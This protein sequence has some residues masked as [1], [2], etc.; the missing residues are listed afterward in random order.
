MELRRYGR[1]LWK[2]LWLIVL[3]GVIAGGVTFFVSSRLTPIYQAS[4]RLLVQQATNLLLPQWT[5]VLTSERL[6]ANYAQLLT[7]RPVLNAVAENLGLSEISSR[8]VVEPVRETQLIVLHVEDPNP[9]LATAIANELP[10]EFIRQDRNQKLERLDTSLKELDLQIEELQA[11][12]EGAQQEIQVFE[13]RE[14]NGEELA[15]ADQTRRA[16][17]EDRLAQYRRSL[18]DIQSKRDDVTRQAAL[19]GETVTIVEPAIEPTEAIGPRV[20]LNTLIALALGALLMT[21]LVFLIEYLDDTIKLPE[22]ASRVTHLPALGS[23]VQYRGGNDDRELIT[24]TNPKSPFSEGY[25]TLRTNIQ[26]SSPDRAIH[27][28]MVTSASPGEGKSTTVANLAVVMAQTGK[29]TVLVDTDLR[30]PVLHQIFGLPNAVGVTTALLQPEGDDLTPYLQETEMENLW[31][32]TS[33][34]QPPNPSELLGSKRMAELI[35]ELQKHGDIL[36][37]DTPPTLAVTDAAVLARLMDGVLL[38]VESAKTTEAAARRAAQELTKVNANVLGVVVNR[39]SYRLAGSHY[40]YYDYYEDRE[41]DDSD[42]D[43]GSRQRKRRWRSG[44][45]SSESGQP[46]AAGTFASSQLRGSR[47]SAQDV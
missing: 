1:I 23:L 43:G 29:R 40:Y 17:L 22:D 6:A 38:V 47:S 19:S 5:D 2:W 27:K 18:F 13:Q 12:I 32:M 37:F 14:L 8:I 11:E 45:A 31:V 24:Y 42:Q 16:V 39:I 34:V 7:T 33:G 36:V 26:F 28:L 20:L 41:G 3:G 10:A 46:A 35:E 4:T 44:S 25:R 15:M 9:A 30:R 21:A